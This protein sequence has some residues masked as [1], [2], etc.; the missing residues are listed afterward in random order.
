MTAM[1]DGVSAA[2]VEGLAAHYARQRARA[3]VYVPLP[4][5]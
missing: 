5:K 2:D 1:L 3:V 4:T